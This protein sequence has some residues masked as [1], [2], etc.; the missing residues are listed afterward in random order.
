MN[1]RAIF[2]LICSM[3][4]VSCGGS[5]GGDSS[6]GTT[7]GGDNTFD[8]GT[9]S[10]G[11]F[12]IN[13]E[14]TRY[15]SDVY[16]VE[17]SISPSIVMA[18]AGE[19]VSFTITT[20]AQ[21]RIYDVMGCDG[22]LD[23]NVYTIASVTGA[24]T[25]MVELYRQSQGSNITDIAAGS[26]HSVLLSTEGA[27]YV[28]GTNPDGETCESEDAPFV[29]SFRMLQGIDSID[30][31]QACAN[32]TYLRTTN[33]STQV[34]GW[35]GNG[36]LGID[37]ETVTRQYGPVPL[38]LTT[39]TDLQCSAGATI[40]KVPGDDLFSFGVGGLGLGVGSSETIHTPTQITMVD[41]VGA[42]DAGGG[43]AVATSGVNGDIYVWGAKNR[44]QLG[45]GFTDISTV[46]N[47]DGSVTSTGDAGGSTPPEP[48]PI[49]LT[50]LGPIEAI[51]IGG[52][53]VLL[54]LS[55]GT[56]WGWG[57]N[58]VGQLGTG[59]IDV[60]PLLPTEITTLTNI[61]AIEAE[62]DWSMVLDGDGRVYT[63]GAGIVAGGDNSS[64]PTLV[65]GLPPAAKIHSG[66]GS[67]VLVL[68][69][70]GS[71]W[72]WGNVLFNQ[73]G[74]GLGDDNFGDPILIFDGIDGQQVVPADP[75][76]VD[77]NSLEVTG[78]GANQLPIQ[79]APTFT[80]VSYEDSGIPGIFTAHS[81]TVTVGSQTFTL[82]FTD[83][84]SVSLLRSTDTG[85]GSTTQGFSLT[86]S[87]GV[88]SNPDGSITF[89]NVG[90]LVGSLQD[91]PTG[92][93][94]IFLNGTLGTT[95]PVN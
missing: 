72:G 82:S 45:D 37:D 64:E 27:V 44:G 56:V 6:N 94:E 35:N 85:N 29:E 2:P 59:S 19:S 18:D 93:P 68:A 62:S 32:R 42:Y 50:N 58:S 15:A 53:H 92:L 77:N 10:T 46:T 63:F 86:G 75:G 21:S 88:T 78:S 39:V 43:F 76:P 20:D 80:P 83:G 91:N 5:S 25:V 31:V 24:C 54:L 23:G 73:L 79:V 12:T 8:Q 38:A 61:V 51:T 47:P 89:N 17:G 87:A 90:P 57:S 81:W 66:G 7:G 22:T 84:I 4:I 36:Q 9:G 1:I 28:V 69:D 65:R 48:S 26:G 16:E 55:D 30:D 95:P 71:V 41:M 60:A 3:L 67:H 40:A 33:G 52:S 13:T 70:D 14:F 74:I 49:L 34:C 11:E